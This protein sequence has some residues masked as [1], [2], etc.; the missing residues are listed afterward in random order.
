M[1]VE[2]PK[3][4]TIQ[5]YMV[6]STG[7]R[8]FRKKFGSVSRAWHRG[9]DAQDSEQDRGRERE[10]TLDQANQKNGST[11]RDNIKIEA[12]PGAKGKAAQR[13]DSATGVADA[14]PQQGRRLPRSP[15][16]YTEADVDAGSVTAYGTGQMDERIKAQWEIRKETKRQE[17]VQ[18]L[19]IRMHC[20]RDQGKITQKQQHRKRE[21]S[22]TQSKYLSPRERN[23][24][25]PA[26]S[27][28]RRVQGSSPA[29]VHVYSSDAGPSSNRHQSS[30]SAHKHVYSSDAGPSSAAPHTY[31]IHAGSSCA[32]D[33]KVIQYYQRAQAKI[34]IVDI[35][36]ALR[37][38]RRTDENAKEKGKSLYDEA[39]AF[40]SRDKGKGKAK[41]GGTETVVPIMMRG[42]PCS[43]RRAMSREE[44]GTQCL[45]KQCLKRQHFMRHAMSGE[46][47]KKGEEE[48][49]KE[50]GEE[51]GKGKGKGKIEEEEQGKGK[52]EGKGKGRVENMRD[53]LGVKEENGK[54]NRKEKGKGKGKEKEEEEEQGKGKGKVERMRDLLEVEEKKGKEK[55]KG[56]G[57][58]REEE[59]GKGK[60]KE[61]EKGRVEM[62]RDMLEARARG[63][64]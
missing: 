20:E 39:V 58:E 24:G 62:I 49:R 54:E 17:R 27:S 40:E 45:R 43:R 64:I 16:G 47:E 53:L 15:R 26:S 60:G 61:K 22:N 8:G 25:S 32:A 63:E 37:P 34:A 33:A 56:K 4:T 46:V 3:D 12:R 59:K 44:E 48:G 10:R 29:R 19:Q 42:R 50:V 23:T 41:E 31:T 6:E 1:G 5:G 7:Q 30:S 14:L 38:G 36:P 57:R 9:E 21:R 18:E 11:P 35:H 51:K 28:S 52:E 2:R 55:E 13:H